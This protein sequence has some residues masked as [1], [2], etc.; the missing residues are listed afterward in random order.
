MCQLSPWLLFGLLI[1]GL[2]HVALSKRFVNRQFR[3]YWGVV[4]AVAIGVPLPLCSCGV[5]PAGIGLKNDGA[6]DGAAVGFLVSTPQTGIDSVVVLVSFVFFAMEWML[7][8]PAKLS[9]PIN[10]TLPISGMHCQGCADRVE[11]KLKSEFGELITKVTFDPQR[12]ELST[13][14]APSQIFKLHEIIQ[15]MGCKVVE[16]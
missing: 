16:E 10:Q 12:I 13:P 6:D 9:V 2:L 4:K 1:S 8:S 15:R 11:S 7:R 14:P 5:I 3:G